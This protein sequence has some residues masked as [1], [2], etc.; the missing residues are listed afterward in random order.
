MAAAVTVVEQ[1]D[2]FH[3]ADPA[4]R[5][6]KV[7]W[8]LIPDHRV[9][10]ALK[11]VLPLVHRRDGNRK[12]YHAGGRTASVVDQFRVEMQKLDEFRKVGSLE[13]YLFSP[14]AGAV[15]CQCTTYGSFI[16]PP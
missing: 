1:I 7:V 2:F 4:H 9:T 5:P 12:A 13:D 10:P 8:W 16:C 14:V 11:A 3:A 6:T 15:T